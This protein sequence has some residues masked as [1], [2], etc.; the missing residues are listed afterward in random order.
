MFLEF[1]T[2]R[3]VVI[4]GLIV[5]IGP[6]M[7]LNLD[8]RLGMLLVGI[9]FGLNGLGNLQIAKRDN[10]KL[11]RVSGIFIL[12]FGVFIIL[13]MITMFA[14]GEPLNIESA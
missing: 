9:I 14:L 6:V 7:E 12:L 2:N 1:F 5:A 8:A 13:G 3:W 11:R 4:I 10:S